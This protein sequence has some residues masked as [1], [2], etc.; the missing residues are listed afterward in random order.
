MWKSFVHAKHEAFAFKYEPHIMKY[1]EEKEMKPIR[2]MM[3]F[4]SVMYYALLFVSPWLFKIPYCGG[5]FYSEIYW[6]YGTYAIL[7]AAWEVYVVLRIQNR[8]RIEYIRKG[9]RASSSKRLLDFNRWHVV[10]LFMGQIARLDTFL[11][12]AFIVIIID[13]G[14]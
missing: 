1:L 13:C 9:R 14:W 10:E 4:W 8:I 12:F 6:C 11:D 3:Y 7:N 2:I 5:L